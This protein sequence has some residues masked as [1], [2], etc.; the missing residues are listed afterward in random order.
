[1]TTLLHRCALLL[2]LALAPLLRA[3]F[4]LDQARVAQALLGPDIW[5]RLIRI[6]NTATGGAYPRTLHALV[7][8][9]A[10]ILWFY[11]AH[12]GTQSLSLNHGRLA[13]EK[14]DF[15][16]L[17]RDIDPG[18]GKW[19]LVELRREAESVARG[20]L[21]NGCFIESVA[22]LRVRLARGER[23]ERPQLLSF[24][25]DTPLGRRGHTVLVFGRDRQL[26]VFDPSRP[27]ARLVV[28]NEMGSDALAVARALEGPAVVKAC[29]VALDFA[30]PVLES[31]IAAAES[32]GRI[33]DAKPDRT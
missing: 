16:P 15:G 11:T 32:P 5:S 27:Q 19:S 21:P 6:E 9:L 1:M 17:L 23:L 20:P 30:A 24:Y 4:S 7:F 28:A 3:D 26:E 13:E 10:G 8:E 25:E 14:A 33:D 18:F 2:L 29:Y 22:D 31:V 12:D